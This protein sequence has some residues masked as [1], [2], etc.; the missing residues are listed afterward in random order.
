MNGLNVGDRVI[1]TDP[2]TNHGPWP[3]RRDN[4]TVGTVTAVDG[5]GD[6][7]TY[8]VDYRDQDTNRWPFN[9]GIGYSGPEHLSPAFQVG[10]RVTGELT[11]YS[12]NGT[13]VTGT[14]L[15]LNVDGW[16]GSGSEASIQV[17]GDAQRYV[18]M[19]SLKHVT[20]TDKET[21]TMTEREFVG[22]A[23]EVPEGPEYVLPF[24]ATN[25]TVEDANGRVF[26]ETSYCT[27]F[28]KDKKAAE[29]VRDALNEKFQPKP[30]P[31][32]VFVPRVLVL[33]ENGVVNVGDQSRPFAFE[34]AP[35]RFWFAASLKQAQDETKYMREPGW[36]ADSEDNL[37]DVT[38]PFGMKVIT[39]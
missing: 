23:P 20:E 5:F 18:S 13:R 9:E 8:T 4:K 35:D 30:K 25:H 22:K 29:L 37:Y 11:A 14:L 21:K 39:D 27:S 10:D 36:A 28:V 6:R 38:D 19:S 12:R 31:E 34:V 17:D 16:G 7:S 3:H 15:A 26:A 2:D 1:F 32:P 24:Q 33:V